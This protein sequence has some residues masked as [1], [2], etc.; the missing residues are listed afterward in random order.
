MR[1]SYHKMQSMVQY[2]PTPKDTSAFLFQSL[3]N[4]SGMNS[5]GFSQYLSVHRIVRNGGRSY[6]E[7]PYDS[8]EHRGYG[9]GVLF[10]SGRG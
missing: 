8:S 4:R 3:K 7:M 10:L 6:K 1:S 5:L 9:R 2:A